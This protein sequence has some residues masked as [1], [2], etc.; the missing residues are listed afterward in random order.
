FVVHIDQFESCLRDRFGGRDNA[1]NVVPDVSDL[2][3]RE[4]VLIMPNWQD[5]VSFGSIFAYDNGD[6]AV[7]FLSASDVDA[8]DPRVW[9][10]RVQNLADQHAGD[11]EV[12]GIFACPGGL[13]SRVDHGRGL[14]DDGEPRRWPFV[15]R[16]WHE[17]CGDGRLARPV[18]QSSTAVFLLSYGTRS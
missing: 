2:V 6:D 8:F 16:R 5:A 12:V 9:I 14:A 3:E 15:V 17:S 4:R 7:E 13:L 11:T 10:G 18:E 1:G